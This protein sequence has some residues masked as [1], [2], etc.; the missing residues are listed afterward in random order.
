MNTDVAA[1]ENVVIEFPS[2]GSA[3]P[4]SS[5]CIVL[6]SVTGGAGSLIAGRRKCCVMDRAATAVIMIE[7]VF[8]DALRASLHMWN[9]ERGTCDEQWGCYL[10]MNG[11]TISDLRDGTAAPANHGLREALYNTLCMARDQLAAGVLVRL[12]GT[13]R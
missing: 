6:N 2:P 5:I 11:D 10:V 12:N 9:E 8:A 4:L 1:I 7:A 3:M 13:A